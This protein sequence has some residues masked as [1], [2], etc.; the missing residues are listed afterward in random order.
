MILNKLSDYKL[1]YTKTISIKNGIIFYLAFSDESFYKYYHSKEKTENFKCLLLVFSVKRN[2]ILNSISFSISK[3]DWE[4]FNNTGIGSIDLLYCTVNNVLLLIQNTK[5]LRNKIIHI[6][7]CNK[8]INEIS[9][10]EFHVPEYISESRLMKKTYIQNTLKIFDSNLGK[11]ILSFEESEINQES[12]FE[13]L[14]VS[15]L[16]YSE[17]IIKSIFSDMEPNGED[18][19]REYENQLAEKEINKFHYNQSYYQPYK[20]FTEDEWKIILKRFPSKFFNPNIDFLFSEI[21]RKFSDKNYSTNQNI[22][23]FIL[24]SLEEKFNTDRNEEIESNYNS[25]EWLRDASGTSD[26]ET[27]NDVYWNLD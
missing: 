13:I 26:P 15:D 1:D 19:Y 6:I 12:F 8:I 10:S 20:Y 7:I 27:Q 14:N 18:L 25:N 5:D 24:K 2:G 4:K 17:S 11:I 9:E 21:L 3:E 23:D 22:K 16:D